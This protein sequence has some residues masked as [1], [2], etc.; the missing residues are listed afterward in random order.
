MELPAPGEKILRAAIY[1]V[2]LATL[3]FQ[4]LSRR[5]ARATRR[6]KR[7]KLPAFLRLL[8]RYISST[9]TLASRLYGGSGNSVKGNET[10]RAIG[11]SAIERDKN[12]GKSKG[13]GFRLRERSASIDGERKERLAREIQPHRTNE[14]LR[15]KNDYADTRVPCGRSIAWS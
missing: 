3:L 14:L 7:K 15:W 8:S 2:F 5:D 11:V 9:R 6:A 12:G 13:H 10:W 1:R 4:A